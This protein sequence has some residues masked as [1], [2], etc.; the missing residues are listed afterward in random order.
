M[1]FIM[2]Y[3]AGGGQQSVTPVIREESRP[4]EGRMNTLARAVARTH[5][6]RTSKGGMQTLEA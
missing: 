2:Y 5:R 6:E 1:Y 4:P 3:F